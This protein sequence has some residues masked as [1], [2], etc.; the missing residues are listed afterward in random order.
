MNNV[1]PVKKGEVVEL[2]I[3]KLGFGGRGI[4]R[5]DGYTVFVHR[6]LPGSRVEARITRRKKSHAEADILSVIEPSPL[7]VP[8]RCDHFGLCGGCLHQ[9]LA[10]DAQLSSKHEQVREIFERTEHLRDLEILAP[11]PADPPYEYR[12][13]MEYSFSN[14]RWLNDDE[15]GTDAAL[16]RFALGL[17]IK[18]RFDRVLNIDRCHLQSEDGSRILVA[19]REAA[20]E[21]GIMAYSTKSHEGFWRFLLIRSGTNTGE[22]MVNLVT[23]EFEPGSMEERGAERVLNAIRACGAPVTTLLHGT[24]ASKSSVA[25]CENVRTITGDGIIRETLLGLSF[26]IG[27]NTFF[28]TNTRQGERLFEE[29]L[30]RGELTEES[31]VWDLYCGAGALSLPIAKRTKQVIGIEL[32]EEAVLLG[33]KNAAANG[34]ENVS[35]LAADMKDVLGKRA[36]LA[37]LPE[38]DCV[39]LDPPRDGLHPDVL[40]SLARFRPARIVYVSCNPSTF[41]RDL[42]GLAVAGY[43]VHPVRPVDMFPHTAHIECVTHLTRRAE[44]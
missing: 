26:E 32:I 43:D 8:A 17:H 10:Y 7:A 31:V 9:N 36:D 25:Y 39:Y 1:Y 30:E 41:A 2:A 13:K 38:P 44:T 4:A 29:A 42:D 15:I 35:F 27:P 3:E 12:N 16:D 21:S 14:A 6:A 23:N 28:Q 18:G 40:A 37:S 5:I 22:W 33:R 19:A 24:T 11:I 34:I 20:R